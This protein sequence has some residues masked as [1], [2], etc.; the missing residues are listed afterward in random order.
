MPPVMPA[1]RMTEG[2]EGDAVGFSLDNME[3]SVWR[4]GRNAK[5]VGKFFRA[6]KMPPPAGPRDQFRRRM[7][8]LASLNVRVK[9]PGTILE[10]VIALLGSR[11]FIK[12]VSPS[13]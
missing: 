2:T 1:M 8:W 5:L 10:M 6:T 3:R 9:A 13:L 12:I 7:T 11:L 4:F